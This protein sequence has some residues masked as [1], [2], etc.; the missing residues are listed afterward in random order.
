MIE[1]VHVK[2]VCFQTVQRK[3]RT[4][5]SRTGFEWFWLDVSAGPGVVQ[6]PIRLGWMQGANF[7]G[8]PAMTWD[9]KVEILATL[10]CNAFHTLSFIHKD[11]IQGL[12]CKSQ[13]FVYS[14]SCYFMLPRRVFH[15]AF[16]CL[17]LGINL[18]V[19]LWL[20]AVECDFKNAEHRSSF[21]FSAFA[22]AA[23]RGETWSN[24]KLWKHT[25][26]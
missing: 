2:P 26:L 25:S 18:T 13:W 8:S 7:I 24:V 3:H 22:K 1:Y 21:E 9:Y 6:L 17:V 11:S 15:A 10:Y 16:L 4:I 23:Q 12:Q 5:L 20:L 14:I 19:L